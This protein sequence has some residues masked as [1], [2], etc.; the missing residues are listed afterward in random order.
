MTK[1]SFRTFR[2]RLK[3]D[4]IF[5]QETKCQDWNSKIFKQIWGSTEHNW[6]V[7]NAMG[8][9][10]GIACLWDSNI[11]KCV[12]VAQDRHW[13]WIQLE[14]LSSGL[15]FNVVNIY[16]SVHLKAKKLLWKE[17]SLIC[18]ISMDEPLCLVGDF[19]SIRGKSKRENC[20]YRRKDSRGL[21][22]LS[23]ETI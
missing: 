13:I 3:A 1:N 18:S 23:E 6:V 5:L 16:S 21:M 8:F 17:L 4:L 15:R 11:Y 9:S 22:T 2:N 12:G 10:G 19:K 7:Q 20:I 14:I